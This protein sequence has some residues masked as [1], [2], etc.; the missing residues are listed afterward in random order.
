LEG[1][2]QNQELDKLV[3]CYPLSTPMLGRMRDILVI[4][5]PQDQPLFR[6]LRGARC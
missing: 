3:I 5:T 6:R 4:S 2:K 1:N